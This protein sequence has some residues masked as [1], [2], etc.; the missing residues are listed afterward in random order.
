MRSNRKL[1]QIYTDE[2]KCVGQDDDIRIIRCPYT[3]MYW[4]LQ[5]CVETASGPAWLTI[6][7]DPSGRE[8][9]KRLGKTSRTGDPVLNSPE[10][11][12][13]A[14]VLPNLQSAKTHGTPTET[15][16]TRAVQARIRARVRS[17]RTRANQRKE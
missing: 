6:F 13:I 14:L 15:R 16:P 4:H 8:L 7:Q 10:L 12:E 5:M 3:D 9:A 17:G 2:M 11:K 1:E